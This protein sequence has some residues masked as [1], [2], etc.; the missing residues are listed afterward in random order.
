MK[1][2]DVRSQP[3]AS[4]TCRGAVTPSLKTG[5]RPFPSTSNPYNS[6]NEIV[7]TTNRQSAFAFSGE[8]PRAE[9]GT[10]QRQLAKGGVVDIVS[11]R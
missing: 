4:V 3:H 5:G 10:P 9:V 11:A 2:S 1:Y 6:R 8:S 7:G